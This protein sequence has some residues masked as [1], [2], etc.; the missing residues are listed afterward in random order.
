MKLKKIIIIINAIQ[1]RRKMNTFN[2]L[3]LI[4]DLLFTPLVELPSNFAFFAMCISERSPA[5][6]LFINF[7]SAEKIGKLMTSLHITQKL[8]SILPQSHF[9]PPPLILNI[10]LSHTLPGF[11]LIVG[12]F[13]LWLHTSWWDSLLSPLSSAS[14][15]KT[16]FVMILKSV[17][18]DLAT[19]D[20]LGVF[21]YLPD[22]QQSDKARWSI[23]K[24]ERRQK[25][26]SF[27]DCGIF[28][29]YYY[30]AIIVEIILKLE[31]C[32]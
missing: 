7:R 9:F 20:I 26:F 18:N 28:N 8:F 2:A 30:R 24:K 12:N 13:F 15:K 25:C 11:A 16:A 1:N 23:A 29:F 31:I 3:C 32:G 19:F 6:F 22:S 5:V 4:L 27:V 21:V 14:S 10:C 17:I